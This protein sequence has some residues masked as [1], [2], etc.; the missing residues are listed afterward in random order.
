M[1]VS[2][3]DQGPVTVDAPLP[4]PPTTTETIDQVTTQEIS[5][6]KA[7]ETA[8]E[9]PCSPDTSVPEKES[10]IYTHVFSRLY[11]EDK[12]DSIA[13]W[14]AESPG[15]DYPRYDQE[16]SFD[17]WFTKLDGWVRCTLNGG[18][19]NYP[20]LKNFLPHIFDIF[21]QL[22]DTV[23]QALSTVKQEWLPQQ[24]SWATTHATMHTYLMERTLL[25]WLATCEQSE[26]DRISDF[27]LKFNEN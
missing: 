11:S 1:A 13:D 5:Q 3:A 18:D 24:E 8:Q 12:I 4:E 17:E 10:S 9:S 15:V 16:R 7:Q 19:P 23:L 26:M 27:N 22:D 21:L 6:E 20:Q 25:G 14:I 2:S